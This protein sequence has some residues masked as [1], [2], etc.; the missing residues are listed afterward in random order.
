MMAAANHV[1]TLF[2]PDKMCDTGAQDVTPEVWV[3]IQPSTA[4][5]EAA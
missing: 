5:R 2:T 1:I 3:K 4:L